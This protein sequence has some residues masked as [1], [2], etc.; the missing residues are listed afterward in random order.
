[1][2]DI[3]NCW[4]Q[5]KKLS[6]SLKYIVFIHNCIIIALTKLITEIIYSLAQHVLDILKFTILYNPLDKI[7]LVV[8]YQCCVLIG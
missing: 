7:Q 4:L 6:F 5:K 2:K 3:I 8:Y 1:M